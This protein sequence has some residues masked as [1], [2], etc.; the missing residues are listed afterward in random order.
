MDLMVLAF[1]LLFINWLLKLIQFLH[2]LMVIIIDQNDM[3]LKKF[4]IGN[5]KILTN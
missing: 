1:L 4:F 2:T 3:K 5:C